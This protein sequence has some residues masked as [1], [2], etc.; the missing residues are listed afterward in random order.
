MII[1]GLFELLNK[2]SACGCAG[3]YSAHSAI[4][5][6]AG[7]FDELGKLD[8][9]EAFASH[10]G[11]DFYGLPRN[12]GQ[13][14]LEKADWTIPASLDFADSEIIPFKAGELCHWKLVTQ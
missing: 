2:E 12:T 10:H 14:T 9:L 3:V 6:Y 7:I 5:L 13:I 1:I 4:E 11:A 8:K